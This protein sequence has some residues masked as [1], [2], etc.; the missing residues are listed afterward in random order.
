MDG[1]DFPKQGLQSV[2]MKRQY[3]GEP[4]KRA[5]CEA[6]VFLGDASQHGYTLHDRR[7]CLPQEWVEDTAYA[8]RRKVYRVPAPIASAGSHKSTSWSEISL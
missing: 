5:N 2:G 8:E 1:S 4:G 7:L 6:G 3:C